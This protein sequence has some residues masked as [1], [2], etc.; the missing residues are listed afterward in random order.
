MPLFVSVHP[1]YPIVSTNVSFPA[2]HLSWIQSDVSPKRSKT[3]I[4]Y[5]GSDK[6]ELDKIKDNVNILLFNHRDLVKQT[7]EEVYKEKIPTR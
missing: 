4:E 2:T 3:V 1:M 5:C 6:D 7:Y